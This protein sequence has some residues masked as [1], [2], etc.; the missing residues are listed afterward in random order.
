MCCFWLGV[1]GSIRDS[2]APWLHCRQS[3]F[4]LDGPELLHPTVQL[5]LSSCQLPKQD[6]LIA[7]LLWGGWPLWGWHVPARLMCL[8][9]ALQ[10][11]Q[12][13]GFP[14][15]S[16]PGQP[17]RGQAPAQ[18][19]MTGQGSSPKIDPS[20]IPRPADRVTSRE[21][22]EFETRQ[23]GHHAVPPS[24]QV[25]CLLFTQSMRGHAPR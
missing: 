6:A 2:K 13:G 3:R 21:T 9:T 20:Q 19:H 23:D 11:Q 17:A 7:C 25:Q 15:Q 24:A 1:T 22:A 4:C 12:P 18:Q 16:G 5:V 8:L 14:R 10:A